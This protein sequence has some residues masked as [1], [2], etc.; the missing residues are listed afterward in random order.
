[1]PFKRCAKTHKRLQRI[2]AGPA[3]GFEA[4]TAD[5]ARDRFKAFAQLVASAPGQQGQA[6]KAGY[7]HETAAGP[8]QRHRAWFVSIA[9]RVLMV[10]SN[11]VQLTIRARAA[12][13]RLEIE[14]HT[15]IAQKH[16]PVALER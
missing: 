15:H 3:H 9:A 4:H 7:L 6:R 14:R 2:R 11:S 16:E 10:G 12:A 5:T 13:Q 8:R 1:M